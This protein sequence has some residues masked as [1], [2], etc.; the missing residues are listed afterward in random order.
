MAPPADVAAQ[1]G[2]ARH[3]WER[4]Y[5]AGLAWDVE[6]GSRPVDAL[7]DMA[8][9]RYPTNIAIDFLG[10]RITYAEL[11][12][13]VAS[14]GAGL[15]RIGV[16]R[17]I[18]VALFLPN[19]PQLIY[20]FFAVLKTGGTVVNCNPLLGATELLRQVRDSQAKII[21]TLDLAPLYEKAALA[22]R[23]TDIKRLV[24]ASLA[25]ELPALKGALFRL[26]HLRDRVAPPH[27]D[28][29]LLFKDLIATAD[30]QG[31]AIAS[32]GTDDPAVL[33]YTGGTS[34]TPKAVMLSHANLYAN[35]RQISLW[36]T[37]A[38]PGAE[39]ILAIL[40]LTHAFGMTA[41][42]NLAISLGGE[43]ILLPRLKMKELLGA[44]ERHR[45]TIMIGVPTLYHAINEYPGRSRYDLSSLQVAV[46]GGDSLPASVQRRFEEQT[47][48]ALAE[49]Y[50]LSECGPVVTCSNPPE[51]LIRPGS[52]GLPLPGTT[53]EIVSMEDGVTVLSPNSI[54]EICV[55]GPQVMSGYWRKPDET[56]A[57]LNN[58]RLR[59]GDVGRID[60]DG[61]LYF[62]DRLKDVIVVHGY[63]VYPRMVEEVLRSHPAVAEVAVVAIAE[64]RRGHVPK[65]LVV[66]RHGAEVNADMLRAHVAQQLSPTAVPQ[67]I[68]FRPDLPKSIM[69]KVLKSAL[70]TTPNSQN[71][72][73]TVERQ[74]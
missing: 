28:R 58:G 30:G 45:V 43:M 66:L 15:R 36:F 31:F 23:E 57:C 6:L 35:A 3:P 64:E 26:G 5:P 38:K 56:A 70:Q 65:A 41:V 7:L 48:C 46:S 21:V 50:G 19:C 12:R 29:H 13:T 2:R 55:R 40:P 74:T 52:C 14:L 1:T 63:K 18:R 4:S 33:Q 10:R 67:E 61:Y 32:A 11:A 71:T 42:M 72:T 37:K 17:G 20:A 59:T 9:A 22:A 49:G 51:G 47:G 16:Q 8:A 44:I 27:D 34:G 68:E 24:V 62:V 69:G 73:S 39:R 60:E 25:D 53:V 54:G